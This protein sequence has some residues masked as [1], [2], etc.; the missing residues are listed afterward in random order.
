MLSRSF[1]VV[2]VLMSVVMVLL[3]SAAVKGGSPCASEFGTLLGYANDVPA[4]SN[5]N[6][7]HTSWESH[8]VDHD[9]GHTAEPI[10]DHFEV[11][12]KWQCVEYARR[13]L[14]LKEHVAFGDVDSAFHIWD[15][16][17]VY[18]RKLLAEDKTV[19]NEK[20]DNGV[21]LQRFQ[22]G[23]TRF[24]PIMNDILIWRQQE[25][26]PHG[27][28]AVVVGMHVGENGD[29]F[30]EIAEQNHDSLPW[31]VKNYSRALLLTDNRQGVNVP[32]PPHIP[33]T[34]RLHDPDGKEILGWMRGQ[35]HGPNEWREHEA[36]LDGSPEASLGDL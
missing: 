22:N 4:Y 35:I 29:H 24:S 32:N 17:Y 1:V 21:P 9:H 19:R 6:D 18:P 11:G 23:R 31:G 26:M 36:H 25:G 7:E 10:D 14:F 16:K 30:V 12:M 20:P 3:V 34:F 5:C 27:H 28:I 8:F 13:Y 2:P 33:L 15:L